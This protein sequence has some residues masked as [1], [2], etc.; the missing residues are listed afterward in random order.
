MKRQTVSDEPLVRIGDDE[1]EACIER[2]TDSYVR[3]RLSTDE[4]DRRQRDALQAVTS[5]DLAGLVADLPAGKSPL[6]SFAS[7][8]TSDAPSPAPSRNVALKAAAMVG[9][10]AT[11]VTGGVV[12]AAYADGASDVSQFSWAVA[13]GAAGYLTHWVVAKLKR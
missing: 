11:F 3:G 2:L 4:L 5:A 1:R 6:L 9:V 8:P 12:V 7:G 13:M 10:P